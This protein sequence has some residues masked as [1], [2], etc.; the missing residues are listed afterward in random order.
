M[1]TH[2]FAPS[3]IDEQIQ[4]QVLAELEWDPR[5]RSTQ[6][7]MPSGLP[8]RYKVTRS[9]SGDREKAER[10]VWSAPGVITVENHI[11]VAP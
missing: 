11:T 10:V 4:D 9:S 6:R 8:S 2:T 1:L 7:P 3:Y 5:V